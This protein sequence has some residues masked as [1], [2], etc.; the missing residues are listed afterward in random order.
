MSRVLG[1]IAGVI[2]ILSSAA[3]SL[4]GWKA[5]GAQLA[6]TNAPAELI[7]GLRIG[8]HFGGACLF[9]F[10]IVVLMIFIHRIQTLPA[11]AIGVLYV[12]FGAWAMVVSGFDPFF[13]I[14]VVPGV[15]LLIAAWPR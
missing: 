8:W 14:F 2:L 12:V 3:H 4:M 7:R 15:L 9:T 10:G 5:L 11:F 6:Q 1:L 13:V